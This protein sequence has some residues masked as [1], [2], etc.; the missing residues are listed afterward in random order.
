MAYSLRFWY[1]VLTTLGLLLAAA[2]AEAAVVSGLVTDSTGSTIPDA[3]VT[4]RDI[5]TGLERQVTTGAD[6][7]YRFD[8]DAAGTYLLVV[9]RAGFSEAA[10]TVRLETDDTVD[11]PVTLDLGSFTADVTVTAARSERELR[12]VPLHVDTITAGAVEQMNTLSTGDVIAATVNVTPVGGGPVGVRPRLRGLDSTRLLVLVDGERLNTARMATDRTGADV[13]LVSPDAV[14]RI[15]IVNGAGTLMYGSDALAGTINI[16]TNEPSLTPDTQFLYG[17]QGFYSSNENGLRGTV[18]LGA[19]SPRVAFRVQ[20]GA[21]RYGTYEAGNFDVEETA[22][23]FRSGQIRRT[24]TIDEAFGFRLGAFPDPFNAQYVR[25]DREIPNSQARGNFV[26]ASAQVRV[27][28]RRTVRVRYQ[29]RRMSDIGFPDFASPYFFNAVSLPYNRLD[30][31]SARYEAQAVTPWLANLSLTTYYQ[32]QERLLQNLLPVQFPAPAATFF[33]I[34]VMRLD[35]LSK[36]TQRVWT[37]GMDLQAVL[38]PASRHLLTTGLTWYRDRSRDDRT[39]ETTASLLGQV[40]TGARGPSAVVFPDPIRLGPPVLARPV[41]VPDAAFRDIAVFVQD[42]WRAWT[43]VSIVA[44]LRADFYRVSVDATPGYSVAA[45]VAGARPAINPSTLP[46]PGE[47][48][49]SRTAV[50]GDVGL[51]A[52]PDGALSP[53]VRFGRSYRHPNLEEMLFA[54][55]ATAGNIAPNVTVRPEI[56]NNVD[57]GAKFRRG[58][59]TGGAYVFFNRYEDFIAQDLVVATTPAGPLAQATNFADVRITG[60]E[61]NAEV[62]IVL[63]RGDVLTLSGAA[64]LTRGTVANGVNP[65]DGRPLDGTAADNITPSKVLAA[66]RFT[67]RRGRWWAEYGIRAQGEVSRVAFTVLDSPFLIPQDLLSLDGFA[68]Q[69]AAFGVNLTRTRD[70]AGIVVAV[71]NLT[72]RFYREHFQFAPSRG[73]SFTVGLTLGTL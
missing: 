33:P 42:E 59:A 4:L 6:G 68:V 17:F 53:F 11:M 16:I 73:R 60:V 31:I 26:N 30:K 28:E 54:G 18:S 64:A 40:V 8:V 1:S 72:D 24:D 14:Q 43:D 50:T 12:Q 66:A 13:A 23:F 35:V 51:V 41:R 49:Y 61:L 36:T 7:R 45:V 63:W 37:P 10:R 65:R 9:A 3:R 15:E 5:A 38:V 39:T 57:A 22:Q 27:G 44:G 71:E 25:T 52:Y 67:E 2:A 46:P 34:G 55:P 47:A 19:T 21:E 62:P 29:R 70:R 32:R 48:T 69:R 56:G 58:L 20:G